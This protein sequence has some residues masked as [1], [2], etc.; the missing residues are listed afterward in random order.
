MTMDSR[1]VTRT[2]ESD[3][4]PNAILDTLTNPKQLPD[5]APVF[6][7]SVEVVGLD[8]WQVRKGGADFHVDVIVSRPSGTVDYLREMGPG[9]R[10][11]AYIRVQPRPGSGSVL[12]MTVPIA[13]GLKAQ[14]VAAVLEQELAAMV[15][16]SKARQVKR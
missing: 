11:G 8:S 1:T 14:D 7:D 12:V 4:E 13:P 2:I 16:I 5:W 10:G 3:V 6:A 15:R 9:K